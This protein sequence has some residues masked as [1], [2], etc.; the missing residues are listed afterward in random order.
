MTKTWRERAL[1]A[2]A[3]GHWA[4]GD[5]ALWMDMSTCPAAEI[6]AHYGAS[7]VACVSPWRNPWRGPWHELWEIGDSMGHVTQK[8]LI[9]PARFLDVLDLMEDRAVQLKREHGEGWTR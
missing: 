1:D 9:P 8:R 2:Q 6:A 4:R 7:Y 3:S 5:V